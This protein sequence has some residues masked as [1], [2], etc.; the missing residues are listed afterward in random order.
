MTATLKKNFDGQ[1]LQ[2]KIVD[3]VIDFSQI[4]YTEK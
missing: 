3:R 2:I 1:I 4:M